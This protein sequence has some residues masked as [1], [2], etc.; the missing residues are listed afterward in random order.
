MN[1][2]INA[3]AMQVALFCRLNMN[4]K[5]SIPI[6]FS[7]LGVLIYIAV[8]EQPVSPAMISS[9][10]G[11]TKPSAT[12]ILKRLDKNE[13]IERVPSQSDRRSYTLLVT[14]CGRQLVENAC[15]EYTKTIEQ[16]HLHLGNEN[17]EKLISLISQANTI[18]RS[19]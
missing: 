12:A 1:K 15:S 17:F 6:H 16:V 7:E 3:A 11:I 19:S 14:P 9:F 2:D 5:A 4:R 8:S 10:F 18:L 13:Y